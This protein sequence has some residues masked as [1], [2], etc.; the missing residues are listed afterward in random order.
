M[1]KSLKRFAREGVKTLLDRVG[2]CVMSAER[3]G[4]D[5][6]RDI[7]RIADARGH[8]INMVFD[9]GANT[10]ETAKGALREFPSAKIISF[11]PHPSTYQSFVQE[12]R[13]DRVEA[14]NSAL[15]D[16]E[17]T[18]SLFVYKQSEINS[19]TSKAQ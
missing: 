16:Q 13:S 12:L 14:I 8:P 11:E 6:M 1:D 18:G 15:S 4:L 3:Y 2:Y 9:V 10:G 7:H 5:A 19:L 17:G